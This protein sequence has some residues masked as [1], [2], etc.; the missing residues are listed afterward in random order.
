[1]ELEFALCLPRDEVSVPMVR[2]LCGDALRKL[3]VAETCVQDIELA[4]TEA[5]TN[6]LRHA[7][8][9][10]REYEV[11]VRVDED[12]CEIEVVDAAGGR[13]DHTALASEPPL[14]T[15]ESGRGITLMRA[16]VDDLS[17]DSVNGG[18]VVTLRKRLE[19]GEN[20]IVHH[21]RGMRSPGRTE[22]GGRA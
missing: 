19:L 1:M 12:E 2:R 10:D 5:C 8:G 9:T 13:F 14:P 11:R 17:M 22:A 15:A 18:T 6:V 21:L 16:L 20:S 3:G 7:A 4:V